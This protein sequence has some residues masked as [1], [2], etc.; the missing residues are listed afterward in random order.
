MITS[1]WDLF[2]HLL[3]WMRLFTTKR[4]FPTI[5][6]PNLIDH[7]TF[8][9]MQMNHIHKC[10]CTG[11]NYTCMLNHFDKHL[12]GK[13]CIIHG[14]ISLWRICLWRNT[15][16][17]EKARAWRDKNKYFLLDMKAF[18]QWR[19]EGGFKVMPAMLV[20]QNIRHPEKALSYHMRCHLSSNIS[21]VR[22]K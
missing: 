5:C 14:C 2:D 22:L 18:F 8:G 1:G 13:I 4:R 17:L 20:M 19:K 16:D 6:M 21:T 11:Y 7:L 12:Y 3:P 9:L 15:S 10:R